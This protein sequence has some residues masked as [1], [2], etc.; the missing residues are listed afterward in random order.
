MDALDMYVWMDRGQDSMIHT[1]HGVYIHTE[2]LEEEDEVTPDFLVADA[3]LP[4]MSI[5]R[6]S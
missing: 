1:D 3:Q 5:D 6:S 2:S 4:T